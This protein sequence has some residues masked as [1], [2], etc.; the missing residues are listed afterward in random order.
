MLK[1]QRIPAILFYGLTALEVVICI[2]TFASAVSWLNGTFAGF[3]VY[4][5]TF[6]SV[7]G[8]RDWPGPKAGLKFGG[9]IVAVDG[10]P[11]RQGRDIVEMLKDK[12]PGTEFRYTVESDGKIDEVVVSAARFTIRDFTVVFL[13]PFLIGLIIYVLGFVV[14]VLKPNTARSWVFLIACFCLGTMILAGFENGL[15]ALEKSMPI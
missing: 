1:R 4:K 8:S 5:D 10:Q 14:Y 2:I 15:P 3:L 7:S 6:V 13:I 9:R 11:I 12:T